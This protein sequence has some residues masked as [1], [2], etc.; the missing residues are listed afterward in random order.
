MHILC[1]QSCLATHLLAAAVASSEDEGVPVNSN[2]FAAE[3]LH[4]RV[5]QARREVFQKCIYPHGS[6]LVP[7]ERDQQP[8]G[9]TAQRL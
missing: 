6:L 3:A 1:T 8:T 5:L 4:V 9:T 7:S 2:R